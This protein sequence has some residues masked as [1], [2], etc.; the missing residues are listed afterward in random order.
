MTLKAS[1]L[2]TK[3]YL[4]GIQVTGH[5]PNKASTVAE[6]RADLELAFKLIPGKHKVNLHAIY[7][8]TNE[9]SRLR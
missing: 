4:G 5:Y 7:A 1:Y 9:K 3:H 6:L 2:R 8:D